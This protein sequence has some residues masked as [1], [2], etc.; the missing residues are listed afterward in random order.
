MTRVRNRSNFQRRRSP[1]RAWVGLDA[2]VAVAGSGTKVLAGSLSLS[3]ANIDE[4][5][6]RTVGMIAVTSDQVIATEDQIG[7]FGLI[8]VNERAIAAGAASIPGPITD[9][10]DDGWFVHVPFSQEFTFITAAGF[11]PSGST[12]HKFDFKSKRIVEDGFAIAIMYESTSN[13]E[14]FVSEHIFRLLSMVRGTG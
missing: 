11:H 14:G 10:S 3:N 7:A 9:I 13:S 5:V 2:A 6:L 1:N 12:E 8:V 4:T